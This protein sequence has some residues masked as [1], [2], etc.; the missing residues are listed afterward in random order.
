MEYRGYFIIK[1]NQLGFSGIQPNNIWM[2][3]VFTI[4]KAQKIIDGILEND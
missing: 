4:E 2:F 1:D 3:S